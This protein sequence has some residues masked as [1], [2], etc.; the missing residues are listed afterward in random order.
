[1]YLNTL[2]FGYLFRVMLLGYLAPL[3]YHLQNKC[4]YFIICVTFETQLSKAD[5]VQ[6][7]VSDIEGGVITCCELFQMP[8]E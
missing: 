4:L 8:L 3:K 6:E 5:R 1:M 7:K 2:L